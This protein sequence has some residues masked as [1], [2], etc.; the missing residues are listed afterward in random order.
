M[1]LAAL[2]TLACSGAEMTDVGGEELHTSENVE[3]ELQVGSLEQALHA[4]GGATLPAGGAPIFP[5][6]SSNQAGLLTVVWDVQIGTTN[7]KVS[8]LHVCWYA[9]SNPNNFYTTG[10]PFGCTTIGKD[11]GTW[12]RQTCP[13][14]H[15][16]NG[17]HLK[18]NPSGT[19]IDSLAMKCRSLLSTSE[20]SFPLVGTSTV[21]IP[22]IRNC[23][24]PDTSPAGYVSSFTMNASGNRIVAACVLP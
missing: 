17:Y 14:A 7:S 12:H 15:V 21:L 22:E 23:G 11:T 19:S 6:E 20:V 3:D 4:G 5:G 24:F 13:D 9:P 2:F 1:P 16:V 10:D 18:V 8:G